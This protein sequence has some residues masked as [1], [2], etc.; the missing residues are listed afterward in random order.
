MNGTTSAAEVASR[1][2]NV[3][4]SAEYQRP[5]SAGLAGRLGRIAA[6]ATIISGAAIAGA[7]LAVSRVPA[8]VELAPGLSVES[9]LHHDNTTHVEFGPLGVLNIP[10]AH[11]DIPLIGSVAANLRVKPI[12]VG[13]P[14]KYNLDN[15][16]GLS[17]NPAHSISTPILRAASDRL[18]EG[19]A[20]GTAI[21]IGIVGAGYRRRRQATK[22][23]ALRNAF[24]RYERTTDDIATK[25]ENSSDWRE[26][27]NQV[28][29]ITSPS[30]RVRPIVFLLA[31]V[32]L[33]GTA[34]ANPG[35]IVHQNLPIPQTRP[36]S[37]AL[38][39]QVP[40]LEGATVTGTGGWAVNKAARKLANFTA[41]V[42]NTWRSNARQLR[43]EINNL[44]EH[45]KLSWQTDDD[46]VPVLH[47]S[48]VHCNQPF[49][50]YYLPELIRD[51]HI[52]LV[53]NTGDQYNLANS[54]FLDNNCMSTMIDVLNPEGLDGQRT[55]MV[56]VAGNHDPL[57]VPRALQNTRYRDAAGTSYHPLL[58]LTDRNHHTATTDGIT[59]VGESDHTKTAFDGTT[60]RDYAS[61]TKLLTQ[62]GQTT[63][64]AACKAAESGIKPIALAHEPLAAEA[65]VASGCASLVLSGHLHMS[66]PLETIHNLDGSDTVQ[67]I[68]GSA[69][70]AGP[71]NYN[72]IYS[73]PTAL[74]ESRIDLIR[75]STGEFAGDIRIVVTPANQVSVQFEAPPKEHQIA[76]TPPPQAVD[77]LN[78][79]ADVVT[80]TQ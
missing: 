7:G 66:Q 72:T 40:T 69:S 26:L 3:P 34:A 68:V 55:T 38:T 75:R 43:R 50:R 77:E 48:D 39:A 42:D 70:G 37:P 16:A 32:A 76:I 61:Q 59:F 5:V 65:V 63:A 14:T 80:R 67:Q 47:I 53:A 20:A 41:D 79:S 24:D 6:S 10:A 52:P 44:N 25:S 31:G 27:K 29:V 73:K 12:A 58:P 49:M 64:T 4:F 46:I 8:T 9:S 71:N 35:D 17:H 19:G 22:H 1:T 36:L 18:A 21:G 33:T 2:G 62:Q 28:N 74:A 57:Y 30:R 45:D 13:D 56:Y 23:T 78:K 60:P 11:Q 54:S 15:L 51:F